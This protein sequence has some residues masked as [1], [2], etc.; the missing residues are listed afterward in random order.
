MTFASGEYINKIGATI[1]GMKDHLSS[2][3]FTKNDGS[4]LVCGNDTIGIDLPE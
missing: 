1:T 2:L 4:E 3:T